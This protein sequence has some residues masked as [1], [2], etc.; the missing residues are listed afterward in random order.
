MKKIW[1]D[2]LTGAI[3]HTAPPLDPPLRARSNLHSVTSMLLV[4]RGALLKIDATQQTLESRVS[5]V[6][7]YDYNVVD[8]T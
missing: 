5:S 8:V 7:K 1:S 4:I 2:Q 6:S 3:A